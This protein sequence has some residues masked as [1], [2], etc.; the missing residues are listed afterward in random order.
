MIM[1]S[2]LVELTTLKHHS[3][4]HHLAT[5]LPPQNTHLTSPPNNL[6]L[7]NALAEFFLFDCILEIF[8]R[9]L[10]DFFSLLDFLH[11][12]IYSPYYCNSPLM[13]NVYQIYKNISDTVVGSKKVAYIPEFIDY[14][15]SIILRFTLDL[16]VRRSQI[17]GISASAL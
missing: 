4:E 2:D 8:T 3:Y 17:A 10:S 6:H 13:V 9:N 12:K 11:N 15:S 16:S 1:L 7:Y 14:M 5:A